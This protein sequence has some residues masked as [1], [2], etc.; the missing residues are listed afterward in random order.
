MFGFFTLG[1]GGHYYVEAETTPANDDDV[2]GL[3]LAS[4]DFLKLAS[5]D[6]LLLATSS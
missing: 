4:D 1:Q 5:G 6:Y 2:D 3:Q